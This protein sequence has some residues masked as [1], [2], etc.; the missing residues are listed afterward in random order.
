MTMENEEIVSVGELHVQIFELQNY[1]SDIKMTTNL[2][3]KWSGKE[4]EVNITR[5]I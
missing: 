4:Y 2:I 5:E 3:V 1:F